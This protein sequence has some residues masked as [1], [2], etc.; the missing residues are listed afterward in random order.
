MCCVEFRAGVWFPLT[1]WVLWWW[2]QG[3]E[4]PEEDDDEEAE[5]IVLEEVR[6]PWEG[7]DRDYKYD[8]VSDEYLLRE[9][10]CN[11]FFI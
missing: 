10:Y 2:V 9:A 6:F 3:E 5:G 1:V 11:D 8:E 4:L 7:S